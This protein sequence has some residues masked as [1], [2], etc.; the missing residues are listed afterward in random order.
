[1]VVVLFLLVIFLVILDFVLFVF[2]VVFFVAALLYP[3]DRDRGEIKWVGAEFCI[4][5]AHI[6]MLHL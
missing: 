3:K 2:V 4:F 6:P 1:M 5:S